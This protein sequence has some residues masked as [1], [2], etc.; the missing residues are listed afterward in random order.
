[1]KHLLIALF[2]FLVACNDDI[3]VVTT[4]PGLIGPA[5]AA[6]AEWNACGKRQIRVVQVLEHE[7]DILLFFGE[8][9]ALD[10]HGAVTHRYN[11]VVTDIQI[12]RDYP[13][14]QRAVAHEFGHVLIGP[15][16]HGNGIMSEH[17]TDHVMPE[18]CDS[19]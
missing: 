16:H 17:L 7:D 11:G 9:G 19:L 4:N 5:N 2:V 15:G 3:T 18:D 10:T 12:R 13:N 8:G 1:M 14:L 6:A